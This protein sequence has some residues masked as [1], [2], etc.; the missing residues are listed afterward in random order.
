M[1]SELPKRMLLLFPREGRA[2]DMSA[3]RSHGISSI[4]RVH[5]EILEPPHLAL[6]THELAGSREAAVCVRT[7]LSAF[8]LL[9]Q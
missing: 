2:E 6:A 8:V 3:N 7:P 5:L 9:Y 1:R 4:A